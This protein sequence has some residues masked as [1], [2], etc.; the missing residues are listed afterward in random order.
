MTNFLKEV[1]SKDSTYFL[2]VLTNWSM[3]KIFNVLLWATL[4]FIHL[5]HYHLTVHRTPL[6]TFAPSY[7]SLEICMSNKR[8]KKRVKLPKSPILTFFYSQKRSKE[9][10]LATSFW[11]LISQKLIF[12]KKR[13]MTYPFFEKSIHF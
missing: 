9:F 8:W 4:S 5:S 12:C 3:N 6:P 7:S 13:S 11:F 1:Y 2:M 10:L